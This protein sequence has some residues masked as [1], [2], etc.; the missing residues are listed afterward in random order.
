[1][2]CRKCDVKRFLS[3]L[4]DFLILFV[5]TMHTSFKSRNYYIRVEPVYT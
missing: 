5:S 1:M 4:Y 3:L 2:S